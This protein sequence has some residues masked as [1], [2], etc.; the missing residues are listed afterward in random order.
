ML[1]GEVL[2]KDCYSDL[3]TSTRDYCDDDENID[4][5]VCMGN[6]CNNNTSRVGNICFQCSGRDCINPSLNMD[7]V[8]CNSECYV[9][10]NEN[11]APIRDCADSVS[12]QCTDSS[13]LKCNDDFCNGILHPTI[14]RLKCVKCVGDNCG[15]LL[16]DKS[17]Y[18]EI[19]SSSETCVTIFDANDLA[20]ERGCSS[21]VQNQCGDVNNFQCVKCRMD[22]CNVHRS[23][24]ENSLC[25]SCNSLNDPSCIHKT[26]QPT[27]KS[28]KN[29][30]CYSRLMPIGEGSINQYVERGCYSDLLSSQTCVEPMCSLCSGDLCNNILYPSDRLTCLF[31]TGNNCNPQT[32]QIKVCNEYNSQ[33]QTCITIF[34]EKNEVN[35][36]DCYIDASEGTRRICDSDD[37]ICSKCNGSNCN[38]GI[39]RS[40]TKCFKCEGIACFNDVNYPADVVDCSLG[41]FTGLNL[42]GE[43]IRGCETNPSNCN[44]ESCSICNGDLCNSVQFPTSRRLL[45][46]KCKNDDGD[47]LPTEEKYCEI[48][49]E[50]ER[51]VSVFDST[52][53]VIERGC[54]QSIINKKYC[55]RNQKN[56]IECVTPKC[57][58]AMHKITQCISCSSLDDS[59]CVTNP[60]LTN[61]KNCTMGCYTKVEKE[62]LVRGCLEEL[63]NAECNDNN[64]CTQC[65]SVDKCNVDFYPKNRLQCMSCSSANCVDTISKPCIKHKNADKCVTIFK[66]CKI[67]FIFF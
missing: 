58:S 47:C 16:E 64:F 54:S 39:K 53:N 14:E 59:N 33:P 12:I 21:S 26:D 48:Y 56:C 45:C 60:A 6:F 42:N 27:F 1:D 13:C 38:I 36:R 25:V 51:C 44:N 3:K 8:N 57:N 30:Q 31:C 63:A 52:N 65:N 7:V 19:F 18:C 41:C 46:Y 49:G 11:G 20:V 37:L 2:L 35:Y 40:G 29:N 43:T 62:N 61:I 10:V 66:N 24:A 34:N 4:C 28:C 17:E 67:I 23:I 50:N 5:G 9:G 55:E 32:S 15:E 22:N